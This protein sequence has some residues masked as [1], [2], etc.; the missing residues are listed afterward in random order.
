LRL[1]RAPVD[2]PLKSTENVTSIDLLY[3]VLPAPLIS[4]VIKVSYSHYRRLRDPG[5]VLL[6]A[7]DVSWM[8]DS[9]L[10]KTALTAVSAPN[11]SP[12]GVGYVTRN[13]TGR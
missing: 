12:I 10:Q 5:F 9:P 7:P 8:W 4:E 2:V 11:A 6:N 1:D 3:A 13:L